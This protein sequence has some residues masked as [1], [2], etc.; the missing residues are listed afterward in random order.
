MTFE[1]MLSC[2]A[3]KLILGSYAAPK[4]P[5]AKEHLGNYL[6]LMHRALSGMNVQT[7]E[8]VCDQVIK[9][10]ARGQKPMPEDFL[11][12]QRALY[13]S[14]RTNPIREERKCESCNGTGWIY[15]T[16]VSMEGET[17]E[18][19]KPCPLC[20]QHHPQQHA[21]MKRDWLDAET[22]FKMEPTEKTVNF[23]KYMF[24]N[25]LD[26]SKSPREVLNELTAIWKAGKLKTRKNPGPF[27]ALLAKVKIAEPAREAAPSVPVAVGSPAP[28]KVTVNGE[29]YEVE[30]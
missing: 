23:I 29:E 5:E 8:K 30:E 15:V 28:Q 17:R 1:E 10:M 2:T 27:A 13:E 6:Q 21:P 24:T 18:H 16:L 14:Y 3:F 7:F 4:T 25:E 11:N 26:Y 22:P 20:R 9:T 12:A 19:V